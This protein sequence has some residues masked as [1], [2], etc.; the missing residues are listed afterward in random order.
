MKR[1]F[2][3]IFWVCVFGAVGILVQSI[4]HPTKTDPQNEII[5]NIVDDNGKVVGGFVLKK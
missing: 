4:R 2:L 1:I 3:V 5:F